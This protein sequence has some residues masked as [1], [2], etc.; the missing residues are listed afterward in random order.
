MKAN[1]DFSNYQEW[2]QTVPE[3][4]RNGPLWSVSFYQKALHLFDLC[5]FDCAQL[6][7]DVRGR[8]IA[9]QLIRSSGSVPANIEEGYGRGFGLDYARF[10]A[11]A[12]GSARETQGW[13]L[14]SRHIMLAE[15]VQH[16]VGLC[17]EV[18]AMLVTA[19]SSQRYQFSKKK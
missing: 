7:Q 12:Q 2:Q 13:Y 18:I 16:R 19:E 11:I 8:A 6:M 1:R 17:D 15:V 4:I 10:L 14:R 9:E 5:W 3:V